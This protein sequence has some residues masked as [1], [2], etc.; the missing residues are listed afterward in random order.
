MPSRSTLKISIIIRMRM[1][2]SVLP[3]TITSSTSTAVREGLM[4]SMTEVTALMHSARMCH[5]W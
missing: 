5:L 4:S 1:R 3:P 2:G